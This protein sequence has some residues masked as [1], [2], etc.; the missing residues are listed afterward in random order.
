ME[1]EM[2]DEME[3]WEDDGGAIADFA[4]SPISP[5]I[6]TATAGAISDASEMSLGTTTNTKERDE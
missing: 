5:S 2:Q 4:P 6:T 3:I 1:T